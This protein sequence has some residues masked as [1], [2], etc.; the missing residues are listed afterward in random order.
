M[1][2]W[3]TRWFKYLKYVSVFLYNHLY[4]F[5]FIQYIGSSILQYIIIIYEMLYHLYHKYH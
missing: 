4:S 5:V 2:G 3:Y 1:V